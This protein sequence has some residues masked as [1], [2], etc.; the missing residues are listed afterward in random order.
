MKNF[1]INRFWWIFKFKKVNFK[2]GKGNFIGRCELCDAGNYGKNKEVLCLN[3]K[4]PCK[5]EQ[6]LKLKKNKR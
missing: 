1:I 4:C 3:R 5:F 6:Y 2:Y